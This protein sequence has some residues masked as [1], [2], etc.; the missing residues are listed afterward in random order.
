MGALFLTAK[1]GY[2]F[3][4]AAGDQ[5]VIDAPAGS[6][7]QHGYV[8]SDPDLQSLF[9]ASGRGIKPGTTLETVDN[10]DI[11]PTAAHLLGL[12]MKGVDGKVLTQILAGSPR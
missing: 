5:V 4:G 12:A 1:E 10:L 2:A 6:L 3:A 8:S 9:I 11:A 7:G